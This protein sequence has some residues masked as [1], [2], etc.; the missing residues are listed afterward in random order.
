MLFLLFILVTKRYVKNT[1]MQ[2]RTRSTLKVELVAC[3]R[4]AYLFCQMEK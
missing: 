4:T 1:T 3:C 2:K